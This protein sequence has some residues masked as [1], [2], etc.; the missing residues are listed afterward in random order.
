MILTRVSLA[1]GDRPP[2]GYGLAWFDF[3]RQSAIVM[4]IPLNVIAGASRRIYLWLRAPWRR[5]MTAGERAC[6]D[7]GYRAGRCERSVQGRLELKA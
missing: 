2:R 6:F 7:R 5:D 1:M 3:H 4:P